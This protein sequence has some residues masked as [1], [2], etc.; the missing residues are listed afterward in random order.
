ML[1]CSLLVKQNAQPALGPFLVDLKSFEFHTSGIHWKNVLSNSSVRQI[2]VRVP[3][4]YTAVFWNSI[5]GNFPGMSSI[6][7]IWSSLTFWT[8][9]YPRC[10]LK[11][12]RSDPVLLQISRLGIFRLYDKKTLVLL[13][14]WSKSG[15][16]CFCRKARYILGLHVTFLVFQELKVIMKAKSTLLDSTVSAVC[17]LWLL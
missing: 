13:I 4:M 2:R 15:P 10:I 6:A 7:S 9:Q 3:R 14:T 12:P 17:P 1:D 16:K 11:D 8:L 5:I